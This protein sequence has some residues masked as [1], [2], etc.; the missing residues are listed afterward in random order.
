MA[1]PH[2]SMGLH[3][4]PQQGERSECSSPPRAYELLLIISRAYA[5]TQ[6][7]RHTVLNAAQHNVDVG[8]SPGRLVLC[9]CMEPLNYLMAWAP[10]CV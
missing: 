2:E 3:G 5:A 4:A 8:A 6:A 1:K 9:K 7:C 10:L